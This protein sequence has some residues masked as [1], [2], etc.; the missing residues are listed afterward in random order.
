MGNLEDWERISDELRRL[1]G[2]VA[3]NMSEVEDGLDILLLDLLA[4]PPVRDFFRSQVLGRRS[5][6]DK[7]QLLKTYANTF[8]D[9]LVDADVALEHLAAIERANR[10]RNRL[11]HDLHEV[12]FSNGTVRRRRLGGDGHIDVSLDDYRELAGMTGLMAGPVIEA[13][14]DVLTNQR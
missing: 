4:Q 12:D 2:D 11:I 3:L 10:E 8:A 7:I 1:V 5:I 9:H 13:L 14:A 6:S